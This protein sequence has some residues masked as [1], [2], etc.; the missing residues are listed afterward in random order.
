[1]FINIPLTLVHFVTLILAPDPKLGMNF[2]CSLQ[3]LNHAK[4]TIK[5][6]NIY[7]PQDNLTERVNPV[8]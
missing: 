6:R 5:I 1:M 7:F 8:N 3:P 2:P 4:K